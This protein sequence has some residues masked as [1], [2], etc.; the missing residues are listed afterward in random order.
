MNILEPVAN[1]SEEYV[2][3]AI[4]YLINEDSRNKI[5]NKIKLNKHVLFNDNDSLKNWQN[6]LINIYNEEI[7]HGNKK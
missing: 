1:N 4:E 6:M 5:E 3:K 2:N 7:K